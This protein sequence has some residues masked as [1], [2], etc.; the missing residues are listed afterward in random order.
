ME[1]D[2]HKL[3][4]KEYRRIRQLAL[5]LMDVDATEEEATGEPD[6]YDNSS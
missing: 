2:N 5:L 6:A 3:N 4:D 1:S